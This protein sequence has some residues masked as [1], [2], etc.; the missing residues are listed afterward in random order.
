MMSQKYFKILQ[1]MKNEIYEL[2]VDSIKKLSKLEK[3][4]SLKSILKKIQDK[5]KKIRSNS[6]KGSEN[7]AVKN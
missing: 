5:N 1:T 3:R 7:E 4:L 6:V 2:K